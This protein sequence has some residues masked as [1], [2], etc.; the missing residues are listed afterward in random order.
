MVWT[1]WLC[2]CEPRW[3]SGC[4]AVNW[5][6]ELCDTCWK[7]LVFPQMIMDIAMV[8]HGWSLID[9]WW[10]IN[11]ALDD[12]AW[13]YTTSNRNQLISVGWGFSVHPPALRICS[14]ISPAVYSYHWTQGGTWWF[15]KHKGGMCLGGTKG[16]YPQTGDHKG[17]SLK[18]NYLG[19]CWSHVVPYFEDPHPDSS[20]TV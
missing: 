14:A 17:G 4:W 20:T 6:P 11:F 2:R 1:F 19:I 9:G 13:I 8:N 12:H 7:T 3:T 18:T 16:N 10:L 5:S 15:L